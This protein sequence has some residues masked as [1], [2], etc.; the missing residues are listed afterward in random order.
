MYEC[1][2]ILRRTRETRHVVWKRGCHGHADT[3]LV[4]TGSCGGRIQLLFQRVENVHCAQ[5]AQHGMLS[6]IVVAVS[7]TH[8][9]EMHIYIV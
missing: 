6:V 4:V 5:I 1:L 3:R 8:R 2:L 9:R 7:H